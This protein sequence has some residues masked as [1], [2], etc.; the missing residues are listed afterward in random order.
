MIRSRDQR[1][2]RDG[3]RRLARRAIMAT[4]HCERSFARSRAKPHVSSSRARWQRSG[5]IDL[6]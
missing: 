6:R 2:R 3:E 5:M 4:N 1:N